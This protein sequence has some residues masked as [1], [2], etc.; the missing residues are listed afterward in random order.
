MM[1]L[2]W[3]EE[4]CA[5]PGIS[6]REGPVRDWL[7]AHLPE[8]VAYYVDP[9]GSLIVNK[10]NSKVM[11]CAHMDEVGMII[12]HITDEGLLKFAHVGGIERAAYLGRQVFV[13]KQGLPGVVG[14][15]PVH[16][17]D[18]DEKTRFP[19][20]ESLYIDIGAADKEDALRHVK[21]GDYAVFAPGLTRFGSGSPRSPQTSWG[22]GGGFLKSKALDDRLGC[23]LL[24]E[25]LH[26]HNDLCAVF[27]AREEI[28]GAAGAAA[29]ALDPQYAIVLETTTAADLPGIDG[30]QRVCALGGGAVVPFMDRGTVYPFDLYERAM[31]L[32][33]ERGIPAQTKTMVAG[34]TDAAGIHR[35]RGGVPT[36]GLAT[37]C[38][39]LHSPALVVKESDAEAVYSLAELLWEELR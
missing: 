13:G 36:L 27:S 11:L 2:Q 9:L 32:A 26:A 30:A 20:Q 16:L 19:K 29:F 22:D 24:L 15:A 1:N 33:K 10:S 5:L 38:R 23:L 31:A 14:L 25:L 17:L 37:P 21:L 12:T 34:A 6:G 39:N 28:G 7:I 8:G 35:A 4:L 18:G 3:L